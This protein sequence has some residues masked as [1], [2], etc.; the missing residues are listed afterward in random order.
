MKKLSLAALLP[1]AAL[2]AGLFA[3]PAHADDDDRRGGHRGWRGDYSHYEPYRGYGDADWRRA[4]RREARAA[5]EYQRAMI[6]RQR[7][8]ERQQRRAARHAYRQAWRDWD[9][10]GVP[11][12]YDRRPD[13]PWRY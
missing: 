10:D 13:N 8:F 11:N 6:E 2:A 7:H 9:R 5:H 12:A 1:A 3:A 4:Q